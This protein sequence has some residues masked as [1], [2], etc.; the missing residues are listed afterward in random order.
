MVNAN[1]PALEGQMSIFG[2]RLTLC[3][4]YIVSVQFSVKATEKYSP[5]STFKLHACVCA[6][7]YLFFRACHHQ[8]HYSIL[9][10]FPL[11]LPSPS[12]FHPL[13]PSIHP[14]HPFIPS[15]PSIGLYHKLSC[16]SCYRWGLDK[17]CFRIQVPWCHFGWISVMERKTCIN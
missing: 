9:A 11:I 3:S 4:Y 16:C 14:I 17:T 2:H 6:S 13:H 12:S 7:V 1:F 5:A 10:F 8:F 15:H